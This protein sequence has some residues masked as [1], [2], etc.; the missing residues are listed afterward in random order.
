MNAA[1]RHLIGSGDGAQD[2]AADHDGTPA[3]AGV[4]APPARPSGPG[5]DAPLA[6]PG[7]DASPAGLSGVRALAR[8]PV[9]VHLAVLAGFIAAGIEVSWPRASYLAGR[10][11]ATRDAGSYVWGFWWIA[12]QVE[13]LSNPWYTRYLAAPVG[14]Q[15]GLHALMPLPGVLMMPVTIMFG[16]SASYNLLSIVMPGL[17]CYALY[18]VARLWLP[19]QLGAI[20]AGAFFGL[21]S[22]LTWRS[23][24][25]LNLAAGVLFLPLALEAAVRLRRRPGWRRAVVLGLVVGAALL[26]DQEMAVLVLI[27]TCAALLPWLLRRPVAAVKARSA[28][29]AAGVMLIVASSQI[30]ALMAQV[31]SGGATSPPGDLAASYVSYAARFPGMFELSPRVTAFAPGGLGLSYT[32]PIIDGIPTYGLVLTALAVLG[33][34]AAWRRRSAW[35]LALLW[36]GC[37]V[38]ALGPVLTIGTH[39]FVPDAETLNGVRLS[40]VMPYTWFVRIPG[41]SGFREPARI[42]ML[43]MVPAA[44]LAGAAVNWLR[45]HAAPAIIM[46]LALGLL[47]AGWSGNPRIGSMPTALPAVDGPIAADHSGS[48]VVD[49][50]FGIRGGTQILGGRFDPEAQVLATADGHPRAVAFLSRVPGPTIAAISEH[51]FYARLIATAHGQQSTPAQLAAAR[52]DARHLGIGWVLVWSWSGRSGR[53]R[54]SI[55]YLH[56]MGF[57]LDYRADGVKVYRPAALV[58]STPGHELRQPPAAD[59][60]AGLVG[61]R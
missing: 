52:L 21:S 49:V 18:R 9:T 59:R 31:R 53:I 35:L 17:L 60:P 24:Y 16:P 28:A 34:V 40:A 61:T 47:E 27:L 41:L 25:H 6:G 44:L 10:L 57:R 55:R 51:A 8:H 11:P 58:G 7:P 56:E 32:G 43:G 38:L 29:L 4:Q 30:I 23:W 14:A 39:T 13:Y 1:D 19:S 45:Y 2:G 20:G 33:L 15:L 54:P 3:A 46:V 36:L 22:M 5:P 48:I 26:T 37:S 50:P 42:L 12:R